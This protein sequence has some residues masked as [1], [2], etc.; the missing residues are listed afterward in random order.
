MKKLSLK[1][2]LMA[3]SAVVIVAALSAYGSIAYFTAEDTARNV[4]TAGNVK[5]E[6]QEKML[7]PEGEKTVPFE[8]PLDVMPGC[9]VSKI[10]TVKNTGGQPA[11]VRVSVEKAVVL[12]EGV[13]G[14]V[15]LSLV[16]FNLN[17]DHWTEKDGFY[18]YT[19][20]LA[21]GQT[22]EPLFTEVSFEKTMSNLYQD[23][24]A[25]LTIN[26][27]ATQTAHNGSTVF[28]AAGWPE[29]N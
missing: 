12:A 9:E 28:E 27:Y 24:K 6:L 18:Y 19:A 3:L 2:K 22:T 17:T 25:I 29:M 21:P 20:E 26:A 15:D 7:T 23:G 11:W 10:V 14:E 5:I 16:S 8:D 1:Q 13:E 4:I